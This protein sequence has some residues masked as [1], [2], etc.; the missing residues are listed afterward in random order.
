M[1]AAVASAVGR[2]V[3]RPAADREPG[4]RDAARADATIAGAATFERVVLASE[5]DFAGFRVAAR[6]L[7]A[8]GVA[9]HA[10]EWTVAGRRTPGLLDG[11]GDADGNDVEPAV[12]D[13][14][15]VSVSDDAG[16]AD[17]AVAATRAAAATGWGDDAVG[18]DPAG[19]AS[20]D[21]ERSHRERFAVRNAAPRVPAPIV[22]LFADVALHRDAQRHALIYRLLWRARHEPSL[23]ADPIDADLTLAR[24][25]AQAVRR[26]A[27]KM[28]AFVRFRPV[29]PMAR[30]DSDGDSDGAG[31]PLHLAWFVPAHHV[32]EIAAPFFARR[33]ANLRWAILTP[34]RSVRWDGRVLHF[35][36]AADADAAAA[37]DAG[38]A[39]WLTY[40]ASIFNPARLNLATMAR[41]MPRRYWAALPEAALI[42]PLAAAAR[43]RSAAM[44][45][46][47]PTRPVRRLPVAPMARAASPP[48]AA[49][50]SNPAGDA[51]N[52]A[53]L[54]QTARH[55]AAGC[56][57]CPLG[58]L[59][60]QTVW[61]EGPIDAALMVVGEQP[62]DQE[63]LQGRP[64]VGPSGQLLARAMAALGWNRDRVYVTNAVKHF[65]YEPR[66]KR[67]IHK[68][69]AQ[70]EADACLHWLEGEISLVR[71]RA[72]VALGA[73]AARQ[74]LG[75]PVAVT[76]ERGAWLARGDGVPVLVTLHPSALLRLEAAERDA[77]FAA[78]LDDLR[79]ATPRLHDEAP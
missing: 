35:G 18:A 79:V 47:A 30:G 55:A 62:G 49:A 43:Q 11:G 51:A 42:A 75:R 31:D 34:D 54:W 22:D 38:E 60:T 17:V 10:V 13:P 44:V 73:T 21:H 5:T 46:A 68:T 36:P 52:R 26:D 69:P 33:F 61:G 4:A 1:T 59:A 76:R 58:A 16:A 23:W 32:V 24:R 12:D 48:P 41:E 15:I 71:P 64:F 40:Y 27:H 3:E 7:L 66:G 39:L 45:A 72:I 37:A 53:A 6:R 56:R 67:R 74:V 57:E 77:A 65:K 50:G 28:R 9:P 29:A 14:A 20:S 63:D 78:W 70:R 19:L 25:M 8:A 2:G